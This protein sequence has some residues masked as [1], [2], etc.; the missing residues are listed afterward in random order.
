MFE[1]PLLIFGAVCAYLLPVTLVAGS[2]RTKG[3][4]KNGWLIG[5]L[6]FSWVAL[7]LYISIVPK[8]GWNKN[9]SKR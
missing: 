6:L 4:E 8:H 7:L 9:R 3:H 2:K 1:T 5:I